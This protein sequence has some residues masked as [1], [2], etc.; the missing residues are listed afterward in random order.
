M[1]ICGVFL[2]D[3]RPILLT[4][5]ARKPDAQRCFCHLLARE[6]IC[7]RGGA[8]SRQPGR[9]RYQPRSHNHPE[10][11]SRIGILQYK[12]TLPL[13]DHEVVITF[14]DG[15]IPPYTNIILD[16]LASQCVKVLIFWSAK[17]CM[18]SLFSPSHLQCRAH[19]RIA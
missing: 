3:A 18:P 14:D 1:F 13:N 12:Q 17:W 7:F 5:L 15:P 2:R 8:V 4:Q 10:D 9:A 19:H 6:R 16:T 11:F